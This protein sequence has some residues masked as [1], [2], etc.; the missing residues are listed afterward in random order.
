MLA[1]P[2]VRKIAAT[3][4]AIT[5]AGCADATVAPDASHSTI[6]G[7]SLMKGASISDNY[8]IPVSFTLPMSWDPTNYC[9]LQ[10]GVTGNGQFHVV[11]K[12][13]QTNQGTWR[14][15]FNWSAH[16]TAIGD[17]G[18]KYVFNYA[19]S[20]HAFDLTGANY[21]LPGV[22][23][24]VDHF[25]MLGQGKAPDLKVSFRAKISIDGTD[26]TSL[27]LAF[28]PVSFSALRV[29]GGAVA[30]GR[31]GGRSRRPIAF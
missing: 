6:A 2:L 21:G 9:G 18:T 24:V 13:A 22:F 19:L 15:Q 17:D 28:T 8:T 3:L 1:M 25:N 11:A 27:A 7:P 31:T 29:E 16:G 26:P 23:D 20:A 14:V 30:L 12:A 4:A 5:L 10:T